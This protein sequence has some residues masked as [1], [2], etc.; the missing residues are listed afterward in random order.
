MAASVAILVP[1]LGRPHLVPRL[2]DSIAAATPGRHRVLF[3]CTPGD[4]A[5]RA[6]RDNGREWI[7]VPYAPGDYAR[8]INAGVRHTDEPLIF[9]GAIDLRFEPGWLERA[10]A[11]ITEGVG[12]VGTNDLGNARVL[13]GEHST[14]SLVTREYAAR[15]TIDEPDKLLHE[16]YPHEFVDDEFIE[17]ARYRNAFAF[18]ADSVVEHLH[19]LWG[20]APTDATYDAHAQRMRRG[21]L[22]YQRRRHLWTSP[23]S[24][25]PTAIA[26]GTT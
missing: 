15:G 22:V 12:V 24:S 19:P 26:H 20:K 14:H 18:A 23:S 4:S 6:V 8:K 2:L 21:R 5:V 1:M 9:T 7:E 10:C 25:R 3:V 11:H 13:A 17:T 16:G